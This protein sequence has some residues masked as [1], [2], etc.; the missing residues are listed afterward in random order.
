MYVENKKNI[1]TIKIMMDYRP[2]LK[3]HIMFAMTKI[4][5][6]KN[7]LLLE[8]QSSFVSIDFKCMT[9]TIRIKR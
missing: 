7:L 6:Q 1:A 2:I 3:C 5:W 9:E 8:T 4:V